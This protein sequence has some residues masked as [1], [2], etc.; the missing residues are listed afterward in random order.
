MTENVQ[1]N[2]LAEALMFA[3]KVA[4]AKKNDVIAQS[5]SDLLRLHQQ[6]VNETMKS[7]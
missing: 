5:I 7:I 6:D 3:M 1:C 4:L 2:T